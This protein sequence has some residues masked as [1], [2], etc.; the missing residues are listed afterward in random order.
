M[1]SLSDREVVLLAKQGNE[2]AYT[3]L[4]SRYQKMVFFV[5][6]KVCNNEADAH[7]VVQET[8]IKVRKYI[9]SLKEVDAF[10]SWLY[11]I[12]VG[13]CK[14]LFRKNYRINHHL[15]NVVAD[16]YTIEKRKDYVPESNM[17]FNN[18]KEVLQSCL[19]ALSPD[20]RMVLTLFYFEQ[21][22]IKE[23]ATVMKTPEGT[24]K[25]RLT[26]ARKAMYEKITA[27]EQQNDEKITFHALDAIMVSLFAKAFDVMK[28]PVIYPAKLSFKLPKKTIL[29]QVISKPIVC[30][31]LSLSVVG[32]SA[33]IYSQE[34]NR[35]DNV[36]LVDKLNEESP[37]RAVQVKDE[38]IHNA[39]DAY[40]TL[41]MWAYDEAE[42]KNKEPSEVQIYRILY[43]EVKRF[44]GTY[45]ELLVKRGW[46][47]IFESL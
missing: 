23:I 28:V 29:Q 22:T 25:S 27:Y 21:M 33:A 37:F 12:V 17:R 14:H 1:N 5:A 41:I 40:F 13:C 18:D 44:G 2:D 20:Q 7:D 31:V 34:R 45:Y 30:G 38:T 24:I 19:E 6:L 15:E 46:V 43:D 8:F 10:K 36:K 26:Y 39:R 4:F 3:E 42:L 9:A 16:D 35:N 47:S 11:Q 32:A